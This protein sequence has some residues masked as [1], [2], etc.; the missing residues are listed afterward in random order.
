MI[1][2]VLSWA[3]LHDAPIPSA[4]RS[5]PFYKTGDVPLWAPLPVQIISNMV[6]A[7]R[8]RRSVEH[9]EHGLK[10][11]LALRL[12][13]GK[14]FPEFFYL[15]MERAENNGSLRTAMPLLARQL[16]Y[17]CDVAKERQA[18]Y[19]FLI[20]KLISSSMVILF[21]TANVM[22]K[23]KYI[24]EDLYEG[25]AIPSPLTA[26]SEWSAA[27]AAALLVLTIV[28][29]VIP[30]LGALGE[31]IIL[32][33]PGLSRNYRRIAVSELAHSMAAFLRQGDDIVAAAEWSQ[34][35]SRSSWIRRRLD[36]FINEVKLGTKW[37]E[38]WQ[39]MD[40]CRPLEQWLIHNASIREDPASG[41]E[42]LAEWLH[43][44]TA[45]TTRRLENWIDPIATLVLASLVGFLAYTVMYN[46]TAIL[47]LLT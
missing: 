2:D 27:I 22:P 47:Y 3:V 8:L 11:S 23:F 12:S 43:E 41:F 37:T 20:T 42:L 26:V 33:I 29:L 24:F 6:W 4:L 36:A 14:V 15:S 31:A 30:R 34:E 21:I 45:I 17:P 5:L 28:A 38:A 13:F 40:L 19:M 1:A 44:E 35:A 16:N 18:E 7:R 46:L 25:V 9:L 32:M 39:N 10:L